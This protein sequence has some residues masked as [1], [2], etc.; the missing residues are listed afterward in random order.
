MSELEGQPVKISL[1]L[2]SV[3]PQSFG[4]K[5]AK[6]VEHGTFLFFGWGMAGIGMRGSFVLWDCSPDAKLQIYVGFFPSDGPR[7][8]ALFTGV[9]GPAR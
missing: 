9:R 5:G 4:S 7:T 6:T 3:V 1:I 2:I 8:V